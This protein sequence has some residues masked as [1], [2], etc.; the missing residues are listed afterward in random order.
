MYQKLETF[1]SE[2]GNLSRFTTHFFQQIFKRR[3][4]FSEF[5]KQCF[6]IGYKSLPLIALTG[7]IM[8]LVLTIQL[9]PSL[10]SY[11]VES[12]LPDMVGIAI[13]REIGPVITALI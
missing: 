7:F 9:R 6:L 13:I 3:F 12:K 4:E 1:F 5:L 11:G 8:G 10:V 2:S